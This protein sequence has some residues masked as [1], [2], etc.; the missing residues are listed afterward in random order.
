[1]KHKILIPTDFSKNAWLAAKYA[2]RLYQDDACDFYL[3]HVFSAPK[4]L[5]DSLFNM[6]EGSES[7]ET[8]KAASEKEL[9]NVVDLLNRSA[10]ENSNHTFTI[11]SMFNDVVEAI[12]IVVE[13]KD[14]EII[15]S[16]LKFKTG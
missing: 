11:I 14:I 16:Y 8:A 5:M 2:T 4:N 3:L 9:S 15:I 6:V 1:M 7:Y 12:K 10:E 13:K